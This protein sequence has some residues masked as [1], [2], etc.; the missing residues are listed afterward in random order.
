MTGQLAMFGDPPPL[1]EPIGPRRCGG[2][3]MVTIGGTPRRCAL[4]GVHEIGG[5]PYC[6]HHVPRSA[7]RYDAVPGMQARARFAGAGAQTTADQ[8]RLTGQLARIFRIML[9]GTWW[10]LGQISRVADAPESSVSAQLR[11]LR[12]PEFGAHTIDRESA[13]GGLHRYKLT[14]NPRVQAELAIDEDDE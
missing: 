2:T 8:I 13:G 6:R 11:N 14:P 9:D 7:I 4:R 1:P 3:V 5:V 12:K 10:T